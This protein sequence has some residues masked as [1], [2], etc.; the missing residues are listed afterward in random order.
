MGR[1]MMRWGACGWWLEGQM[2]RAVWS[3]AREPVVPVAMMRAGAP[4][5][6]VGGLAGRE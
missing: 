3:G 5:W 2:G 6:A 1:V 4:A